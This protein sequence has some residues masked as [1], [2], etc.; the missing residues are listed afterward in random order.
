M[1]RISSPRSTCESKSENSWLAC[2]A[3]TVFISHLCRTC[4]T[5]Y[6]RRQA[7]QGDIVACSRDQLPP[8][9]AR[10]FRDFVSV[11]PNVDSA[12][13]HYLAAEAK[14]PTADA[15]QRCGF[16]QRPLKR[17]SRLPTQQQESFCLFLGFAAWGAGL[18][19]V[20]PRIAFGGSRVGGPKA[21]SF[22]TVGLN[23]PRRR[24]TIMH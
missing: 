1:I 23:L 22:R 5:F 14:K 4:R 10:Q 13:P 6:R 3:L 16:R 21:A 15:E 8:G 19:P 12:L 7:G 11:C 17:L 18:W 2:R 20:R 24:R 9:P